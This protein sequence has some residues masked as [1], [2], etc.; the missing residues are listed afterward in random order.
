MYMIYYQSW[1]FLHLAKSSVCV[2]YILSWS[3]IMIIFHP[4][5]PNAALSLSL[6]SGSVWSVTCLTAWDQ[7]RCSSVITAALQRW[8]MWKTSQVLQHKHRDKHSGLQCVWMTCA[9]VQSWCGGNTACIP[10][11]RGVRIDSSWTW[12]QIGLSCTS[13]DILVRKR[14]LLFIC[15]SSFP[16]S[17]LCSNEA[18]FPKQFSLL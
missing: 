1:Y 7:T 8:S 9:V 16:C 6:S 2:V 10:A 18:H 11:V 5:N 12:L 13:V 3:V 17:H 4:N 15:S 14:I